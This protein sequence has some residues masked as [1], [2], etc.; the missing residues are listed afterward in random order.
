MPCVN[1]QCK[2]RIYI[3]CKNRAVH[4]LDEFVVERS[5]KQQRFAE[6]SYGRIKV[7]TK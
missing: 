1:R 3:V 4:L 7:V 2:P 5:N 6:R